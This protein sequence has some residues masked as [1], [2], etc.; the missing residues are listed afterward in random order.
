[1]FSIATSERFENSLKGNPVV[2]DSVPQGVIVYNA[3]IIEKNKQ[4]V[5]V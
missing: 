2:A 5:E 3:G 1:M 4:A